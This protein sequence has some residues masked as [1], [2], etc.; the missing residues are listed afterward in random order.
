MIM[1]K[2]DDGKIRND[3]LR[4]Y[5]D[6][7]TDVAEEELLAGYC[8]CGSDADADDEAGAAVRAERI[9][10]PLSGLDRGEA[11]FDRIVASRRRQ[12]LRL[13]VCL[14]IAAAAAAALFV[15]FG[16][17]HREAGFEECGFDAVEIARSIQEVMDLGISDIESIQARPAAGCVFL[18]VRLTDGGTRTYV[19]TRDS[20]DGSTSMMAVND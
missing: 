20:F 11:E 7:G 17:L 9:A 15:L 1:S 12:R 5:M 13:P 18:E 19:M 4:R 10:F 8:A 14:G 3:L 2:I 16:P 6:A